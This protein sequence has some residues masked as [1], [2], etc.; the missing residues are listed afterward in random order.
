MKQIYPETTDCCSILN[1]IAYKYV[2]KG[3]RVF[4]DNK[5]HIEVESI[6]LGVIAYFDFE[7][8]DNG[9]MLVLSFLAFDKESKIKSFEDLK[10]MYNVAKDFGF[11]CA[12]K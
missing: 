6:D 10:F 5:E 9:K 2:E 4:G 7:P 8:F 12:E 1:N 3:F 11:D